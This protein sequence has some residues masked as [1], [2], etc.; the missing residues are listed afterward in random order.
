MFEIIGNML[1]FVSKM[2]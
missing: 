2:H 1:T